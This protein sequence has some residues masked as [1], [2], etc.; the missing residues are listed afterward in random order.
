MMVWYVWTRLTVVCHL[1]SADPAENLHAFVTCR[2]GIL[3]QHRK[4]WEKKELL[5]EVNQSYRTHQGKKRSPTRT[6]GE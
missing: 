2:R 4:N 6:E 3:R 1:Y 5:L